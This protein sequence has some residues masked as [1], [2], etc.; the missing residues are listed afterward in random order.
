[1]PERWVTSTGSR[2]SRSI[3]V[4]CILSGESLNAP[5]NTS[6]PQRP[7]IALLAYT[8]LW[9]ASYSHLVSCMSGKDA[10]PTQH[11]RVPKLSAQQDNYTERQRNESHAEVLTSLVGLSGRLPSAGNARHL[12]ERDR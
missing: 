12:T 2:L 5:K 8:P 9:H 3:S 4:K 7:T 6:T 1:M 11:T 10:K